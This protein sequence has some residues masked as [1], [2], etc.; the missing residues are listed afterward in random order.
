MSRALFRFG[1]STVKHAPGPGGV[2]RAAGRREAGAALARRARDIRVAA[3]GDGHPDVAMAWER[4]GQMYRDRRLRDA[5][6]RP[7]AAKAF[8]CADATAARCRDRSMLSHR[9]Q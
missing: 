1:Q 5:I 3:L 9:G 6:K 2:S 4:L 8:G 7:R